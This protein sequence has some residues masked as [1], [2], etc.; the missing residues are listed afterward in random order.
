MKLKTTKEGLGSSHGNRVPASWREGFVL[1][2]AVVAILITALFL[3]GAVAFYSA[4]VKS[5][6]NQEKI[7]F[8]DLEETEAAWEEQ[9]ILFHEE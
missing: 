6:R 1:L 3:A 4:A 5:V 8:E 2:D 9:E 7:L